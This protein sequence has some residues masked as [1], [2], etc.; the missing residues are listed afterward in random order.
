MKRPIPKEWH[1]MPMGGGMPLRQ[2]EISAMICLSEADLK[3]KASQPSSDS[4]FKVLLIPG[5]C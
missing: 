2:L 5:T 3:M 1:E 4:W